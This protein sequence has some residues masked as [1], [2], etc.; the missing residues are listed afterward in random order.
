M[1]IGQTRNFE[2]RQ[3]LMILKSMYVMNE[4]KLRA[5]CKDFTDYYKPHLRRNGNVVFYF[6]STIK[7]GASTAYAV[8]GADDNRFD[9]VVIQELSQMGWQVTDVDMGG[10]MFR[11]DKYQFINDVLSF[12]QTPALRINREAGRNDYLIT[13]IE[14]AG[15]LPGTFKKDKSREKL[16][17]TDPDSLGG[18]P[19]ERTDVTDA[20]DDLLIGVRFHGEGRPKIGGGLRGRFR[21]LRISQL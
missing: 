1:I 15:I 4:R 21:N 9:R 10:A 3:S 18:D 20:L 11:E 6:T 5:L 13:A 14:N 7:Q 8:E 12:Q 17:S 2:G 16:K 19:R